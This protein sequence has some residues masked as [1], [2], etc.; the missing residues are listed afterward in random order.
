MHLRVECRS[1]VLQLV[2]YLLYFTVGWILAI[3]LQDQGWE[4]CSY[5]ITTFWLCINYSF[6]KNWTL[7]PHPPFPFYLLFLSFFFT[8][9]LTCSYSPFLSPYLPFPSEKITLS[10]GMKIN[11]V[12]IEDSIKS[13]IPFL[14]NVMVVGDKKKFLT[15]LMTLKVCFSI[16]TNMSLKQTSSLVMLFPC[17]HV[18]IPTYA[19]THTWHLR[20]ILAFS[21]T[22]VPE[23]NFT[24]TNQKRHIFM[25]THFFHSVRWTL[26]LV[27]L[28]IFS[29]H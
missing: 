2:F 12:P 14:S 17:I 4:Y 3:H 22:Y 10:G 26:K 18:A 1:P 24:H 25:H 19:H 13:E 23:T 6:L 21:H 16:L 28:W 20:Y 15:C 9:P 5:F 29:P 8:L 27:S 7:S 11:P